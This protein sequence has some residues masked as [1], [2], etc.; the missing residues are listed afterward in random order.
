MLDRGHSGLSAA[1][2]V[3]VEQAARRAADGQACDGVQVPR[4]CAANG[5]VDVGQSQFP[6]L[7][8]EADQFGMARRSVDDRPIEVPVA[9]EFVRG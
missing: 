4:A 6:W 2:P 5:Q 8:H 3:P 9:V 1:H 7:S